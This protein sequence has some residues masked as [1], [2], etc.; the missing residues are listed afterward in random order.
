M[1]GVVPEVFEG[2]PVVTAAQMREIDRRAIEEF[3][4]S[5]IYQKLVVS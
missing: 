2:Y 1:K 3:R 4:T 5:P